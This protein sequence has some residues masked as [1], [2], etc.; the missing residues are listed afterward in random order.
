MSDMAVGPCRVRLYVFYLW[1]WSMYHTSSS[2]S[3]TRFGLELIGGNSSKYKL[4]S[5]GRAR[6]H[7][8]HALRFRN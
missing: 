2:V 7:Q 1:I 8:L 3:P 6:I 4:R 5:V